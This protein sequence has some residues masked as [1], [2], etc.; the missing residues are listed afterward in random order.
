MPR[1]NACDDFHRTSEA[2]RRDL[3]GGAPLTR[4][5][6]LAGGLGAGLALYTAQALPVTRV[7]EAAA[8]DAAAAPNAPVL[9]S[10]FLPGGVDLLDTLVPL[11]DFGRYADLHKELRVDAEALAGGSGLG[12]HPSLTRGLN[13]G[14][15]GLF[16][17]GKIGFLPG[18]DYP[19]PDL[20]HF[21]SRHFWE[22][23]L[24]TERSAPG[25]LGRWL[26]RAGNRDNPLQGI[27]MG[28]GLSPVLRSG[29]APVAAVA[30]P[31][32][33][34]FWMRNVWGEPYKEA[35]ATY[36]RLGHGP[37]GSR[38]LEAA[39][40]S[41]RLAK[42]VADRLAPYAEE[43]GRDP[44]A[45]SV[46]YPAESD[47]GTRL[48]YLA[49]L[50]S[51]PLGIR[52]AHV[53]ADGDFDTH[54]N[55]KSLVGLLADV[56]ECLS[57]FQADLEARGV[58]GRVLTLVWSEFG[59][60]PEQNGSGTDHGAGGLAWVQGDRARPGI[61]SDYPSL[62]QLDGHDNLKVTID[63]R[64]VYSSVLEQHLGADASSVIPNAGRLGRV[65]LVR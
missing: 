55:Q 31:G 1:H 43:D 40:D 61:H 16:E 48:R 46:P 2:V 33:A 19:D 14:V 24:I 11:H 8:A 44:L 9:V 32:D 58:S 20:S 7:L 22:T 15:R 13:G 4:R 42:G 47:F 26:D 51:K 37:A 59:R 35:M 17:R 10:V 27:S 57:A 65:Q 45:S 12:L 28:Y 39:R 41:V 38:A 63:F 23:G 50:I 29:R 36:E 6:V 18:I 30:S 52:V 49:A 54:D 34:G 62:S 5:Q 21:H 53:D 3:L 64:R 56:S 60:R 25:W